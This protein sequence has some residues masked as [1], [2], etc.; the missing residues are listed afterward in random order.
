MEGVGRSPMEKGRPKGADH[1]LCSLCPCHY[2]NPCYRNR[3][4]GDRVDIGVG[5]DGSLEKGNN[6]LEL[7]WRSI[8][9]C[10]TFWK[11]KVNNRG[12]KHVENI[13]IEHNMSTPA[14]VSHRFMVNLY[15]AFAG[16]GKNGD[17]DRSG[18]DLNMPT[19]QTV[20]DNGRTLIELTL[21]NFRERNL[22]LYSVCVWDGAAKQQG[23]RM[24]NLYLD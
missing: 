1:P 19:R 12:R 7:A 16:K 14:L 5:I 13:S 3:V 11:G 4:V 21:E 8:E 9:M 23:M 22:V 10:W 2:R 17:G 18:V 24:Y 15:C 20:D 6:L